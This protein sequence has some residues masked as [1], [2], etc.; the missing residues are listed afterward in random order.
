[1]YS[2]E[3]HFECYA[4]T[5]ITAVEQAI[6]FLLEG[7][8]NNGQILGREFPIAA[9]GAEF[10]VRVLLPDEDALKPSNNSPWVKVALERLKNAKL[11]SPRSRILGLDLNSQ[12]AT[13][14]PIQ[15]QVLYT[16]YVHNCSPL[17][18]GADLMPIPLY[19]I[20]ATFNGDHKQIIRWQTQW[21]ACD[22]L[23]MAGNNKAEFAAL[24][25]LKEIDSDLFRQ[26]WD[27]R[28]RIEYLTKTPTY[29]YQYQVG[30]QSLAEQK[31]RPCPKC[32]NPHWLLEQPLLDIFHFKCDDCRI[33]SNISWEYV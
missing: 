11:L 10:K 14:L 4:D 5:T 13:E 31:Q 16:S 9:Q 12:T 22:E 20:P 29:Y 7:Y 26:G 21:Q 17:R 23:Q 27:L 3:I 6:N 24:D 15:W 1:M 8:R 28:G 32:G 2:A 33:V 19:K 30:G 18:N 25:E